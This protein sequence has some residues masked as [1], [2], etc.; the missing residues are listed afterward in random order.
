MPFEV[1]MKFRISD[2]D[3]LETKLERLGIR[4][5]AEIE[6]R[7]T[8]YRHP[9]R[10]FS[11]TDEGLRLRV[12]TG[13]DSPRSLFL[14]YKGPKI[15]PHTKTRREIEIALTDERMGE[16]LETLGFSVAGHVHKF[17]RAARYRFLEREFHVLWDRLPALPD[18]Y[19]EL[20]IVAEEAEME[21]SRLVLL[22]LAATL[23][24]TETVRTSYF[25]L[26][27]GEAGG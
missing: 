3:A 10:D 21:Q 14:T 4:F 24:L 11:Q 2:P 16:I 1:E 25:S 18:P 19:L 17:R 9:V 22:E 27:A 15:D 23:G 20:E 13:P 26:V 6:E 5:G 8:F 7:D 12:A